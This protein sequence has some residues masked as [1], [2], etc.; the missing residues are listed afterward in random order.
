LAG[1]VGVVLI[2][3][4]MLGT[5]TFPE[6]LS[7]PNQ[8]IRSL[9]ART[10]DTTEHRAPLA[11]EFVPL[12]SA[13]TLRSA[14]PRNFAIA[15]WRVPPTY[16]SEARGWADRS[17]RADS[18]ALRGWLKRR[19]LRTTRTQADTIHLTW[20]MLS[21]VAGCPEAALLRGGGGWR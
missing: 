16:S 15:P 1:V 8:A 12:E 17:A 13:D 9:I 4:G 14:D 18:A 20:R 11:P 19:V 2:T 10:L 21:S 3:Y 6:T 5:Y 7:R